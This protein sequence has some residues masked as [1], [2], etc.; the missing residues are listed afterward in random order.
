ME[1][2]F[3]GGGRFRRWLGSQLGGDF[4]LGDRALRR[5]L[6]VAGASVLLY[7]VIPSGFFLI[8]TT[9]EIL[10]G[11]LA[12]VLVIEGLR[13][14]FGLE[15]AAVRSYESRRVGSYAYYAV[16]LTAAVL[17]LPEPIAVVVVLGTAFVDPFMGELR[18]RAGLRWL[19][20]LA[21]VGFY[22]ALAFVGLA[23]VGR[24]PLLPSAVL[25]IAAAAVAVAA[26]RPRLRWVDDDLVMTLAPAALL[27]GAAVV[28]LGMRP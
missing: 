16:A 24:W 28:V 14:A 5:I 7:F 3:H 23:G 2:R 22:A 19:Y 6:H 17:L 27:L 10:L 20:P 26:E 8:A 18:D 21:P 4:A 11:L 13:L 15:M 9:E 12:A 1:I 25:A